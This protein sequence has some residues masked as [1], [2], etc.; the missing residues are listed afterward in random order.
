MRLAKFLSQAGICSRRQAGRLIDAGLVSVDGKIAEQLTFVSGCEDIICDGQSAQ[1][2][3][4]FDYLLYNKPVG[5]NC[6][7]NKSDPSSIINHLD[8]PNRLFPVGRLDKDSHGLLLL[9]NNGELCHRLLAPQFEHN[10]RYVVT[11]EPH[12]KVA[13][14]CPKTSPD[15]ITAMSAGIK[16]KEQITK[17]CVVNLLATN[18]FEITLTQGLNRQIRRMA[19]TQGY[20]V[21]DLQRISIVNLTLGDLP[22]GQSRNLSKAEIAG[23]SHSVQFG[24]V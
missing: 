14:L 17:P 8:L 9:T 1:L 19:L 22:I 18:R 15:F 10:K 2:P 20:K 13:S 5:I 3:T 6:V 16:I 11:V 24:L 4:Q 7:F 23:L 21:V 12:Y